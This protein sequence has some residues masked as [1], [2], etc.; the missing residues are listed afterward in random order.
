MITELERRTR[1]LAESEARLR[2]VTT[3]AHVGLVFV[4][5]ERRYTSANG[6][7]AEMFGL[8]SHDIVGQRVADVLGPVYEEQIRPWLDR[9]FAGECV[10]YELHRH[11]PAGEGHYSVRYEPV[12][13]DGVVTQ[14]GVV[15][16][17]I[18]SK[19]AHDEQL[20]FQH[21]MWS[22]ERELTLDGILAV[23]AQSRVLSFNQRF[24]EMWSISN[25]ILSTRAD[26]QLLQA[27]RDKLVDPEGFM[28]RVRE[29]YDRHDEVSEDEVELTDGRTFDRYSA[30]MRDALGKYYGRIWYFRDVT[31]RKQAERELRRERDRAQQ[32]LD[33]AGVMLLALDIEGRITLV[34]RFAC[35]VLGWSAEELVGRDFIDTCVPARIRQ[36][37][38]E[39]LR[40][41]QTGDDTIVEN[42]IVTRAGDERL[43]E[44]RT[45]FLRDDDGR[46]TGTLS[47]GAD[48]TERHAA[49]EALRATE[50]RTRFALQNANIGIW[51]IDYT[52]GVVQWS[53]T[54]EAHF[55]LEPGTFAGT[56]EAF[57][58]RVHTENRAPL[59]QAL[60]QATKSG[61]DF[62][63]RHRAVRPDGTVRWLSGAGR[64]LLGA[65]GEPLRGVGISLDVTSQRLLEQQYHQAQKMEAVGRLAGGVA[66]DFN[67]LAAVV[68]L[69][70]ELL[71]DDRSEDDP[72]RADIEEIKKA[73]ARAATLTRQL[74]AFSRKQIIEPTLIDLG[75]VL[76]DMRA[77]LERLI[78]ED[79]KVIVTPCPNLALTKADRG[80][81]E[82]VV[83]NLAVN[84]R[85]AMPRGGTLTLETSNVELDD[86]YAKTHFGVQPGRYVALT[87]TDTGCGITP[88][89]QA[90]L[91]EPFFTT[92]DVGKGTGLGLATVHG[93]VARYGGTIGVY[94][95]IGKGTAFKVYLP[96]AVAE[97]VVHSSPPPSARA[98]GGGETVLV[99]EDSQG[100]RDITKRLLERQGY[101]VL[102]AANADEAIRVFAQNE[103][104]DLVLTDVV[105]P[106][107][108]GPDLAE[109]LRKQRPV[110]VIYMSGYTEEA[111]AL[112][113]VLNPGVAFLHK[114]FTAEILGR[115]IRDMLDA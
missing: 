39:K 69:Y 78:G 83:M 16:T 26:A 102:V 58:E 64:V 35:S 8:A 62:T 61:T 17:D 10:G 47:S 55:G 66:H 76:T 73:G 49:I 105:M 30:P 81:V 9:A 45:A 84:A 95:E 94:S 80:Q 115:K 74:L 109:E 85:D 5:A 36:E 42:P 106:G 103:A 68:L 43:V 31:E 32:Y 27:V 100:L 104:I 11:K 23:D 90:R 77:M 93:I 33:T 22:T 13:V 53:P 99:V 57:M 92:K 24:A 20:L 63:V 19:V 54:L 15:V 75:G 107:K 18:T 70:C 46:I 1:E 89:V 82:Q 2:M 87:V 34:N 48:V 91:F 71:L 25:D 98:R 14:V 65:N 72:E 113:G 60:E 97:T 67:N 40:V 52:T 21:T 28:K 38:R 4:N 3:N 112:H 50:E 79:V 101:A 6:V 56:F 7:Y 114:P 86:E 88:E 108:S 12:R 59:L 37:T 110:T 44:W 51:D 29:L 111:I 41:V 96:C